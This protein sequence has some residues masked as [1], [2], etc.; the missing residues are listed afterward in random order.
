MRIDAYNQVGQIYKANNKPKTM[1]KNSVRN[2]D[3]VEISEFGKIYQVAKKA[4]SEAPDIRSSKVDDIKEKIMN[5][6][7]QV[8]PEEFADKILNRM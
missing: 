4:V 2:S 8:S 1:Q 5:G 6:S 3:K 7:Y